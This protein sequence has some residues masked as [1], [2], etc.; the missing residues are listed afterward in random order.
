MTQFITYAGLIV[1]TLILIILFLY[2]LKRKQFF[3]Y[4]DY[5]KKL[6]VEAFGMVLFLCFNLVHVVQRIFQDHYRIY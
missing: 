2:T 6:S 4:R 5:W 3:F 1:W